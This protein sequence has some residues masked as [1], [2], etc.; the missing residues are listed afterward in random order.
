MTLLPSCED[1]IRTL[2]NVGQILQIV[3]DD[4]SRSYGIQGTLATV[5]R[6]L[7]VLPMG[8]VHTPVMQFLMVL[9]LNTLFVV[10]RPVNASLT[11]GRKSP[12]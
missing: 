4:P 2:I 3:D 9:L 8:D 12:F 6:S 7:G 1:D 5:A 11:E 10:A